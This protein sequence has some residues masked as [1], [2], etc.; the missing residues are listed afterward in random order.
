MFRVN[1]PH[2]WAS[3]QLGEEDGINLVVR[4]QGLVLG[5]HHE[6]IVVLAYLLMMGLPL[7]VLA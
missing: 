2:V 4:G 6:P 1:M 3:E 7:P 5:G